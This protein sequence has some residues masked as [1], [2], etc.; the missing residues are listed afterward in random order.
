MIAGADVLTDL[1]LSL[2]AVAG[3]LILH[4]TL[5]ARGG[6]DPLNRRFLF[7]IRVTI[8]LFAA[9]AL[10]PLTGIA[11]FDRI[12]LLAAALVPLAVL[13]LTEGLLRR[14]AP[15]VVKAPVAAGTVVFAALALATQTGWT[16][17]ALLAFQV[18]GLCAAGWLVVFRDRGSLSAAEN[19]AVD[20]L[21]LSLLLLI[22]LGATD[23]LTTPLGF[24]P[25]GLGVLFLCWLA[26]S[27]ARPE[28]RHA[29]ALGTL[30]IALLAGLAASLVMAVLWSATLPEAV[31]V[32][33]V[34]LAA[35]LV[36]AIAT[37]ARTLAGEEQ[38]LSLLRLLAEG[39]GDGAGFASALA[40]HPLV[41][42]AVRLGPADL[43]E[44]DP[45]T[46][47][48]LFAARPVL[49]RDDPVPVAPD[50]ADHMAHLFARTDATHILRLGTAPLA[51]MALAMPALA[52][53]SRAELELAAV[54]RMAELTAAVRG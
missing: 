42:G 53:S 43:A 4:Q 24:R 33:S 45:A 31:R 8:L 3:L 6:W 40:A 49:H 10:G 9:R 20:R 35:A 34:V 44:L 21:G 12:V 1:T 37:E 26:L 41:E 18:G 11:A 32:A 30:G 5:V 27:L 22:P 52:T 16:L 29:R 17:W 47:D 51:L 46:L 54:Q 2:A 14:H 15:R 50:E 19:R 25:S 38:S 48:R 36:A 28:A 7:G 39:P 13:I 23:F